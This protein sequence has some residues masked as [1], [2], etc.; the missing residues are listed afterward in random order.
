MPKIKQT[1]RISRERQRL[2]K[3]LEGADANQR[4]IAAALIDRAAYL[5]VALEDLE[6]EI[7]VDGW[8]EEY[9]NGQNQTGVKKSAA[10][11]AHISL[12]KNLTA[13]TK[14][15]LEITPPARRSSRLDDLRKEMAAG[16]E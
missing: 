10:A 12:T 11:D 6:K 7:A 1:T 2:E 14:Q 16:A 8:T 4:E 15:L 3:I 9:R 13:I 5:T